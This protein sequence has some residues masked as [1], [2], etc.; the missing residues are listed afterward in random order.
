MNNTTNITTNTSLAS[1]WIWAVPVLSFIGF[2]LVWLTGSNQ[3]L[4]LWINGLGRSQFGPIFWANATI[5]GDTLVAVALLSLF[6]R[7]RPE[8]I[9]A[10][11][12]AAIFSTLW[13]HGLKPLMETPRPSAVLPN[14]VIHIIGVTLR[15]DSFPSGHTTT[16]FTLAGVICILRVHP[17]LSGIALLLAVLAG[18]SRATV[19]AHWPLDIF[20]GAFGGWLGAVIGVLLFRRLA[21]Y[22]QQNKQWGTQIP[23]QKFLNIALLMVALSLFVYDNGYPDSQIF[24]YAVAIICLIASTLNLWH[25]SQQSKTSAH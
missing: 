6:A 24:Q 15:S 25:L 19:G 23:G 18:I 20:A 11:L 4:F 7:V 1:P 10:L 12:I 14:E 13:V 16:A 3:D 2:V 17:A 21:L 9:W 22:K 5:L 8:I